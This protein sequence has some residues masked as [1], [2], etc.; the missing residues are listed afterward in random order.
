VW[1]DGAQVAALSGTAT[2]SAASIGQLQIGDTGS[3][4]WD[5][6]Y[7]D[8]AFATGRLGP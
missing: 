6:L 3:G 8:A 1:L 4:T 2:T 5:V 7:D